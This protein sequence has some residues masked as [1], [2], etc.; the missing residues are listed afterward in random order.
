MWCT[1]WACPER[2]AR[3][4]NESVVGRL[5]TDSEKPLGRRGW[6]AV[7]ILN[8]LVDRGGCRGQCRLYVGTVSDCLKSPC[9]PRSNRG[10]SRCPATNNAD[11]TLNYLPDT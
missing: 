4:E 5:A 8:V 6:V 10:V 9:E 7:V 3:R 2:V 11:T 1:Q